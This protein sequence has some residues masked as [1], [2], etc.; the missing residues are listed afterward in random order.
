MRGISAWTIPFWHSLPVV[1]TA[2]WE[3]PRSWSLTLPPQRGSKLASD[4]TRSSNAKIC[5]HTIKRS[6]C[7]SWVGFRLQPWSK[8][9]PV[10]KRPWACYKRTQ[11][12]CDGP[13]QEEERAES[14]S[15]VG[16]PHPC[17]TEPG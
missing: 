13:G 12:P 3:P 8:L 1:V 14:T 11:D 16:V 2:G 6:F 7:V 5:S 9:T 4:S 10:S 17:G 15:R